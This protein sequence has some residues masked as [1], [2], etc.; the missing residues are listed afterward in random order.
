MGAKAWQAD[1][2]LV[3][4]NAGCLLLWPSPWS[5]RLKWPSSNIPRPPPIPTSRVAK[6]NLGTLWIGPSWAALGESI[7]GTMGSP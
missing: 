6:M 1:V 3:S 5:V 7:V 2:G 4:G